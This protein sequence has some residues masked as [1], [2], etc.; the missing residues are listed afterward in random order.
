MNQINHRGSVTDL[1]KEEELNIYKENK[2]KQPISLNEV[3]KQNVISEEKK[4]QTDLNDKRYRNAKN[5]LNN[6]IKISNFSETENKIP[7]IND[8]ETNEYLIVKNSNDLEKNGD[9]NNINNP[10]YKY[11][12][13]ADAPVACINE[14]HDEIYV[15]EKGLILIFLFSF[16]L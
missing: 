9:S 14:I 8:L 12:D 3:E 7:K 2:L 4:S 11:I 15:I 13:E 6:D 10:K 16:F 5:N 1:I